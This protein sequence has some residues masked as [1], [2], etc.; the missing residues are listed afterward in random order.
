MSIFQLAAGK[1]TAVVAPSTEEFPGGRF[2]DSVAGSTKHQG[3][4]GG[5]FSDSVAGI[6]CNLQ[7]ASFMNQFKS[8]GGC[9]LLITNSI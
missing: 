5:Q 2:S 7:H 8:S 1:T 4:S 3:V 6:H 9:W